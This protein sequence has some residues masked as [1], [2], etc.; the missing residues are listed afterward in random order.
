MFDS[1][2]R[3]AD[4]RLLLAN[5]SIV[6]LS[7]FNHP[8][9]KKSA[10]RRNSSCEKLSADNNANRTRSLCFYLPGLLRFLIQAA[11]V[12]SSAE[13]MALLSGCEMARSCGLFGWGLLGT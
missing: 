1:I 7:V 2:E 8:E 4:N 11:P 13:R 12:S 3:K 10:K 5:F 6:D 9:E